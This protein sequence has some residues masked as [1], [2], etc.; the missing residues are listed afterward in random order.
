MT[1]II[2]LA[3]NGGQAVDPAQFARNLSAFHG[4]ATRRAD[5]ADSRNRE[6]GAGQVL[7]L[8]EYRTRI[9][10]RRIDEA[11][12]SQSVDGRADGFSQ[13]A[14]FH[15]A[16]DL[17]FIHS[18]VLEEAFAL[19]TALEFFTTD[20]SIPVGVN[21]HTIRR[22]YSHGEARVYTGPGDKVPRVG[23]TQREESWPIRHIVAGYGWDIFEAASA[24]YANSG[25]LT[26]LARVA[27]DAIMELANRIW[28]G[29]TG[30]QHGLYGILNYPWLAKKVIQTGFSRATVIANPDTILGELH[31]LVNFPHDEHKSRFQPNYLVMT[32][33]VHDVLS[34]VRFAAGS[35]TTILEHF[36]KNSAHIQG[37]E[38]A[39]ELEDIGG[40]G[41]DGMLAYRKDERGIQ[42]VMPQGVTQTPV[43][44]EGLGFSIINYMSL[45]GVVMRDHLNNV[46]GYA[47]TGA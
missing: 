19:P 16:R 37:V 27:R 45:G 34:S 43:Q 47:D 14:G 42:L 2:A 28:W 5:S 26:Q 38:I 23:V 11:L 15:L 13:N 8:A 35:D 7:D 31:D 39:W 3:I 36:L 18:K 10:A 25:L 17:E 4:G 20:E 46:L 40:A 24:G 44:T 29:K 9:N 33:A 12:R 21:S 30:E 41:V 22:V 6:P 1:G 32:N